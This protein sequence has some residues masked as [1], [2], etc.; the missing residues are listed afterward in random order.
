MVNTKLGE[1]L[2]LERPLVARN[3]KIHI[4][5]WILLFWCF[6]IVDGQVQE[7]AIY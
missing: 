1:S 3:E 7:G 6:V 2:L 5:Y 4:D